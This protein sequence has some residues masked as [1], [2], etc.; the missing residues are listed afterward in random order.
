MKNYS[1]HSNLTCQ[2]GNCI[3]R[4]ADLSD[5]KS[6]RG[7][8][9]HGNFT[10]QWESA[11]TPGGVPTTKN[12]CVI[13][14]QAHASNYTTPFGFHVTYRR[15]VQPTN[16]PN[17]SGGGPTFIAFSDDLYDE[18][19][20]TTHGARKML[21]SFTSEPDFGQ[22]MSG[23]VLSKWSPV[24][25]LKITF[26][27]V[28]YP[29]LMDVRQLGAAHGRQEDGDSYALIAYPA[30]NSSRY[31]VWALYVPCMRDLPRGRHAAQAAVTRCAIAA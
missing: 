10:V 4:A 30:D 6:F 1:R 25:F 14:P 28:N 24:Q 13:L 11:Y 21:Y 27:D 26:P 18:K 3:F 19:H 23:D 29:T 2:P 22:A 31:Y 5:P 8:D 15:I 12:R 16:A 7:I 20:S 17:A 9:E